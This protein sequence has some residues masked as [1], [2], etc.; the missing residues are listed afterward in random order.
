[1]SEYADTTGQMVFVSGVKVRHSEFFILIFSR[2]FHICTIL[3]ANFFFQSQD[4]SVADVPGE[5]RGQTDHERADHCRTHVPTGSV[6]P[7]P[8]PLLDTQA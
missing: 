7:C 5:K 6:L 4:T 2:K 3:C 8:H 1:M